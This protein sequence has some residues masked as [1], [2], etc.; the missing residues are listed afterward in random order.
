MLCSVCQNFYNLTE[1]APHLQLLFGRQQICSLIKKQDWEQNYW[2]QFF[3]NFRQIFYVIVFRFFFRFDNEESRFLFD[4]IWEENKIEFSRIYKQIEIKLLYF[5]QK[6]IQFFDKSTLLFIQTL[7]RNP[8]YSLEGPWLC[9]YKHEIYIRWY[10]K[11]ILLCNL[12]TNVFSG[13]CNSDFTDCDCSDEKVSPPSLTACLHKGSS[14]NDV[15]LFQTIYN[16]LTPIVTLFITK[17]LLL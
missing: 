15:T 10:L 16:P 6:S 11:S 5:D 4:R 2:K 9:N 14:I 3:F 7:N 13:K 12:K 8:N 17:A 1:I